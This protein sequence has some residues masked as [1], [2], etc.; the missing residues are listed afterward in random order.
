MELFNGC[1]ETGFIHE[2]MDKQFYPETQEGFEHLASEINARC[3]LLV[4]LRY[5]PE[6]NV[7]RIIIDGGVTRK[8]RTFIYNENVASSFSR[9]E[10]MLTAFAC[11]L[12]YDC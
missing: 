12:G 8:Y 4:Q 5:F 6:D 2:I 10:D 11:G 1:S 7:L 9:I 3:N